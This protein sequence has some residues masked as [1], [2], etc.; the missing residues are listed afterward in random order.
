[1]AF[2]VKAIGPTG[3]ACWL[4]SANETGFRPLAPRAMADVFETVKDAHDAIA[5]LLRAF[6]GTGLIFS[7]EPDP[8]LG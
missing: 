5:V 4:G 2:I 6:E 3:F 7:V 8:R 1:M